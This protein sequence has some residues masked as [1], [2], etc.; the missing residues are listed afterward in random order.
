MPFLFAPIVQPWSGR[1]AN[2]V[3]TAMIVPSFNKSDA[4]FGPC[5]LKLFKKGK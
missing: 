4:E 2:S 5:L 3:S 1:T